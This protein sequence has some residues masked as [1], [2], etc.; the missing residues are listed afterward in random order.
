MNYGLPTIVNAN[1]S[2]AELDS[3]VVWKLP[4]EFSNT[5]LI[6]ALET[7]HQNEALRQ[8]MGDAARNIIVKEHE[9]KKCSELYNEAIESFYRSASVGSLTLPSAIASDVSRVPDDNDLI[10]LGKS[11]AL[12]FP[13][14]NRK[15]QLFVDIS[16]LVTLN[17]KTGIQRLAQNILWEWLQNP[18]EGYR[19]EPVYATSSQLYR[20]ARRFTAEFL[21][22]P[23][24]LLVDEP[25]DYAAGDV[26]CCL[27]SQTQVVSAHR[28][29]YQ[30][31][32]QQ[33]V[34]VS[35]VVYD[36]L[37]ISAPQ[38]FDAG[39]ADRSKPW[40]EVI[41][42]SDGVICTSESVATELSGWLQANRPA[43]RSL[44]VSWFHLGGGINDSASSRALSSEV[45]RTLKRLTGR[46]NF[47]IVG[48]PE[49][50]R[51]H[52]QVLD[53]FEQLW[54]RGVNTNYV[55]VGIEGWMTDELTE[56]LLH[57]P[58]KG[59]RLF[60]F[61]GINEESLA[62]F[63]ATATC[64][65]AP[66]HGEDLGL[67][68]ID[69]AQHKLPII[70]RDIPVFREV[71]G[72]HAYYFDSDD[73]DALAGSIEQWLKLYEKGKHPTSNN[74]PRLT[75]KESAA[76]LMDVLIHDPAPSGASGDEAASEKEP[77]LQRQA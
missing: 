71:A 44:K 15:R 24:Q 2:M 11:M 35:F 22:V 19:T 21:G 69:A 57:H 1:G 34:Q 4:D 28:A 29:F 20:Y 12:D 26:F 73:P 60:W 76:Q 13:P 23:K 47:L 16:E 45:S 48:T 14:R 30:T 18:P 31:L 25:I 53:A 64:L 54:Q 43:G 39:G 40:L 8:R 62:N 65:I 55:L 9:P 49:L 7:L 33:G 46:R 74:M 63:L 6:A 72:D 52:T 59:K 42:E 5:Q 17:A 68:V 58:E 66:S 27:D 50:H 41:S 75:W 10:E 36:P 38:V 67:P 32:R 37:C 3:E 51:G 70:A 56:R 77:P 61:D